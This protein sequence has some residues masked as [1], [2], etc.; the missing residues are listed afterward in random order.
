MRHKLLIIGSALTTIILSLYLF[1]I[2]ISSL[3]KIDDISCY[4]IKTNYSFIYESEKSFDLNL[5]SHQKNNLIFLKDE[6]IYKILL[7]NN[8]YTLRVN[9]INIE[10]EEDIYK[11]TINSYLPFIYDEVVSQSFILRISNDKYSISF[12]MG[13]I[14]I[15]NRDFIDNKFDISPTFA[16][17]DSINNLVGINVYGYTFDSL[18]DLRTSSQSFGKLNLLKYENYVTNI[19]FYDDISYYNVKIVN[20]NKKTEIKAKDFYIPICYKK[21]YQIYSEYVAFYIN[22]EIYYIESNIKPINGYKDSN[23]Y[24]SGGVLSW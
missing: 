4:A 10:K 22:D 23:L 14:S 12:D 3:T 11:I 21:Y 13:S 16:K 15:V 17:I 18:D 9:E 20:E 5:Y 7:D 19:N 2:I 6:N 1:I 8:Q 24:L